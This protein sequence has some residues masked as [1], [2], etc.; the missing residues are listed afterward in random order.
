MSTITSTPTKRIEYIDSIR[1]FTM[2]LVVLNHVAAYCLGVNTAE[3]SVHFYLMQFRMPLFF[4]I[5]G[6]VLYK[7]DFKWNIKNS[8]EFINKKIFVQII[9]PFVFYLIYIYITDKSFVETICHSFKGGFWFTYTL[10]EYYLMYILC[11]M[12]VSKT[13]L[14]KKFYTLT[15]IIIGITIFFLT[16]SQIINTLNINPTLNGLLGITQWKYF[17]FFILGT[18]IK[19]HFDYFQKMLDNTWFIPLCVVGY[20]LLNVF[21][22]YTVYPGVNILSSIVKSIFGIVIIFALFRAHQ[23]EISK[24]RFVGKLLQFI[25]RRTLD[26]YLLHIFLLPRYMMDHFDNSFLTEFP[27]IEFFCSLLL[28]AFVIIACVAISTILRLSP[29]MAHY[30]FG[31]KKVLK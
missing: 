6:F 30:L 8:L 23:N 18:L 27:L 5:S 28:T 29:I 16:G 7:K 31:Q 13:R 21:A 20:I 11:Q 4:F 17:F 19:L 22:A 2:I 24:G 25:G 12:F 10:F 26:I 14:Y 15:L 3:G 1:G 9:S